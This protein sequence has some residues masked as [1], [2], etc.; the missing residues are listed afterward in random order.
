MK[1]T[2]ICPYCRKTFET[3]GNS[4]KFCRK[5]CAI[6]AAKKRDKTEKSFLCQWC[7]QVFTA[8]RKRKF[9]NI[10]CQTTYMR[11][12]GLLKRKVVKI[13]VKIT[14]EDVAK[15]SKEERLTYGRYVSLKK[16]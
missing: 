10:P 12:L 2:K 8:Q 11:K 5:K 14:I 4:R 15:G 6:L 7:G 16:L 9:C 3:D 1:Q 13:P